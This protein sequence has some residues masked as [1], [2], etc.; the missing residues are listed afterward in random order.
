MKIIPAIINMIFPAK[1]PSS[2][3]GFITQNCSP[4]GG[5]AGWIYE[6]KLDLIV[7]NVQNICIFSRSYLPNIEMKLVRIHLES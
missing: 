4:S 1:D 3:Q 2:T 6:R 5:I 7:R